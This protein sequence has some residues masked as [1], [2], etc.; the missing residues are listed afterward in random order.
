VLLPAALA[1]LV[2][3]PAQSRTGYAPDY[4]EFELDELLNM[5]LVFGASRYEQSVDAAPAA[6]TII[7][8]DDIRAFHYRSLGEILA[9]VPGF[10]VTY[11]RSYEYIGVRGFGRPGDYNTRV[12]IV[13][14]GHVANDLVYNQAPAGNE[15]LLDVENIDRVEVIRGPG[16][17]LYGNGAFFAVVNVVTVRGA[18][19]DGVNVDAEAGSYGRYGGYAAWGRGGDD[20]PDLMVSASGFR[21][22][23]D[24]LY[25][26]EYDDPAT[27]DGVFRDGDGESVARGSARLARGPWSLA[28]AYVERTKHV[29]TGEWDMIFDD[30]DARVFDSRLALDAAWQQ[31]VGDDGSLNIRFGYDR[32]LYR[33][34]YPYDY[35][36]P[37][38]PVDP[39]IN[40]DIA[41]GRWLSTALQFEQGW[42]RHR[43]VA[44]GDARKALMARQASF[45][46]WTVA[47][48]L[49]ERVDNLGLYAQDEV[50][51]TD[52]LSVFVG[53]RLDTYESF[54]G[55]LSPRL[56]V[57]AHPHAGTA[58]KALL[59]G[60]FRA[61]NAYELYYTDNLTQKGA[62]DLKP[63]HITTLEVVWEQD[64][65]HRVNGSLSVFH[66]EI[67]DLIDQ[68]VDPADSLITFA[69]LSD[70]RTTGVEAAV[71]ARLLAGWRG[72]AGYTYQE[73]VDEATDAEL[74]NS[75]RHMAQLT[76]M[77]PG[78]LG[79]LS[80]SL[81][82]RHLS[83]RLTLAGARVDACTV[84]D[85]GVRVRPGPGG[86]RADL[87]VRN[88]LDTDYAD[89]G[90]EHQAQDSLAR[91]GRTFSVRLTWH[92]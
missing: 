90:A 16:S 9:T 1:I 35:A 66:N 42:A 8:R 70:V 56:G 68:V 31:A 14:D 78:R 28:A 71:D 72:R 41:D 13:V 79:A 83:S 82:L 85:L 20:G 21:S 4:T 61:P 77:S 6:V 81:N 30:N 27:N 89:P 12:L 15:S 2:A 39:V 76:L 92:R 49:D 34:Y 37:G 23:G 22:D 17:A 40:E 25:W 32:A 51:I 46:P 63:E 26:P 59:G 36:D 74:T 18:A 91:E 10:Y 64:L 80:G 7:T 5:D 29:P 55:H 3:A 44:G 60:A 58:L 52:D 57:V 54:G 87:T 65:G 73:T 67:H 62:A 48:D 43:L 38:D 88:L 47:M 86:V 50:R 33:G 11:D 24:D 75:P 53:G 69:N 84:L 19:V 45:D